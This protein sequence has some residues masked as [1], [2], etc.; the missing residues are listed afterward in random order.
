M[1]IDYKEGIKSVLG[2]DLKNVQDQIP[3]IINC[4]KTQFWIVNINVRPH[5]LTNR[6]TRCIIYN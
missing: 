4:V 6:S 3:D 1:K 2:N 5:S